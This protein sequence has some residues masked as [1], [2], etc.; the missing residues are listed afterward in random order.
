M[1]DAE[2]ISLRIVK[3]DSD[4]VLSGDEVEKGQTAKQESSE[5]GILTFEEMTIPEV[6]Y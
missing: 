6:Y 4:L 1:S 5:E 2:R 3:G